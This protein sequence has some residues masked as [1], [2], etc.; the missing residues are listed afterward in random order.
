MSG[1]GQDSQGARDRPE[2]AGQRPEMDRDRSHA[3]LWGL[4]LLRR[5]METPGHVRDPPGFPTSPF[6]PS[7]TEREQN[8]PG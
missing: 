4:A 2:K 8:R 7:G 6:V 3:E 5:A 1:A